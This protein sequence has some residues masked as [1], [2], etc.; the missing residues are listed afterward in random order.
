MSDRPVGLHPQHAF[1]TAALDV[2]VPLRDMQEA[3]SSADRRATMCHD[4][5]RS[6]S[7]STATPPTSSPRS[8]PAPPAETIASIEPRAAGYRRVVPGTP[9]VDR[10]ATRNEVAAHR[11]AIRELARGFGLVDARLRSDG[12]VVVHSPESG[13]RAVIRLSAAASELVGRYVHVIT[14]DVPGASDSQEL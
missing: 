7:N 4:G 12:A 3:A 1:I 11:G 9:V 14:D 6:H 2:G 5:A 8:S 10:K 13:Y